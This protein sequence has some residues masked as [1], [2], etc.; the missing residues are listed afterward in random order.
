M[1]QQPLHTD[2][3][4]A[5]LGREPSTQAK[6]ANGWTDLHYAALL[7]AAGVV[8]DLL[9]SGV[10]ANVQMRSD[11][12]QLDGDALKALYRFGFRF[13][14]WKREGEAPLHLAAW[15]NATA[16]ARVLIDAGADIDAVILSGWTPLHIAARYDAA[17]TAALLLERGAQL[18]PRDAE[19]W[20][21]LHVAVVADALRTGGMLLEHGA[22]VNAR[23]KDRVTALH[24]TVLKDCKRRMD[25][26]RFARL[27]LG[28][29]ARANMRALDINVTPK[30]IAAACRLP[31]TEALLRRHCSDV[32]IEEEHEAIAAATR[33][34]GAAGSGKPQ[35]R[36][37]SKR[38]NP[39]KHGSRNTRLG[40]ARRRG[41]R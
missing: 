33:T 39:R 21:P 1:A 31:V 4:A 9:D 2:D 40:K 35:A 38:R 24:F 3:L 7:N 30:D 29:G 16:A 36:R 8:R 15:S 18:D 12:E 32:A 6:D 5:A 25:T 13:T 23:A 17:E 19:D 41:R 11:G 27:L 20:T 10:A 14:T 28:H 22:D 26:P 37:P 34:L